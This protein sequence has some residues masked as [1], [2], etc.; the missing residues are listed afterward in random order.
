LAKVKFWDSLNLGD[1]KSQGIAAELCDEAYNAGTGN[2]KQ[3]LEK[4]FAEIEWATKEKIPVPSK[5]TPETIKWIN[6][7]TLPRE[8]RISF[9]NS[10]RIKRVRFYV[11]LVHKKPMMRQFFLSWINRS[12]D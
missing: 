4:V 7:Y 11:D 3:L 12:V 2:P 9:Y 5:F 6:D 1:L 10:I 8:R